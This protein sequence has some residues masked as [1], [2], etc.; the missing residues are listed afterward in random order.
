MSCC[1][2]FAE[3]HSFHARTLGEILV[4]HTVLF[5]IEANGDYSKIRSHSTH[6]KWV[7]N[8]WV[9][10]DLVILQNE[11]FSFFLCYFLYVIKSTDS[12]VLCIINF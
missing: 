4:S 10:F 2:N 1:V 11:L 9:I 5:L 7:I 8:V 12:L 6:F 3:K